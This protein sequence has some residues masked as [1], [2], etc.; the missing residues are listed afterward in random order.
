MSYQVGDS[1]TV[2]D[3]SSAAIRYV[4]TVKAVLPSVHV[5][6]L[7]HPFDPKTG[8]QKRRG[9]ALF[10]IDPATPEEIAEHAIRV[11]R[12]SI[13]HAIRSWLARGPSIDALRAVRDIIEQA[14][15]AT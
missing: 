12:E 10:R 3:I 11:E 8:M 15:K 4:S 13:D 5:N 6:G 2:R 7:D 9:R 14:Q 1:V